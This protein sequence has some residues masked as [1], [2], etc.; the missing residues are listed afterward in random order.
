ML[1]NITSTVKLVGTNNDQVHT[2]EILRSPD[3]NAGPSLNG[4]VSF[5]ITKCVHNSPDGAAVNVVTASFTQPA[6]TVVYLT[7][8]TAARHKPR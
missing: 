3:Q 4:L 5:K 2:P 1:Q 8:P 7:T 6:G